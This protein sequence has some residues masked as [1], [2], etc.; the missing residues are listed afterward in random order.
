[1]S[2]VH[3]LC[4][5]YGGTSHTQDVRETEKIEIDVD[6]A[7]LL[8]SPPFLQHFDYDKSEESEIYI[9]SSTQ[10][11]ARQS[12]FLSF[13]SSLFL[14]LIKESSPWHESIASNDTGIDVLGQPRWDTSLRNEAIRDLIVKATKKTARKYRKTGETKD[15]GVVMLLPGQKLRGLPFRLRAQSNPLYL[16]EGD[17][18]RLRLIDR[19]QGTGDGPLDLFEG[20][21]RLHHNESGP[22]SV[23][24]SNGP[25]LTRRAP[26][27]SIP[28][29]L[30][31]STSRTLSVFAICGLLY[32]GVHLTAWNSQF[33]TSI[34]QMFFR[35]AAAFVAGGGLILL[36][37]YYM[38]Q[39]LLHGEKDLKWVDT[40]F[41]VVGLCYAG[42][43]APTVMTAGIMRVYLVVEAFI[44]VR[45]L[46]LG[47]YAGVNWV[48]FLPHIGS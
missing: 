4:I 13:F 17:I 3:L 1:M 46:P 45:S 11:T 38:I 16:S 10:E 18:H 43:L 35:I 12:G 24:L 40:L 23:M 8:S 15:I 25:A 48:G 14:G 22:V 6:L 19:L 41:V 34:E 37:P 5:S 2:L 20:Y 44:S 33:P 42:A 31:L 7:T 39:K 29:N 47:A 26:N 32:G 27:M 21:K 9:P 28:G 36:I 30:E